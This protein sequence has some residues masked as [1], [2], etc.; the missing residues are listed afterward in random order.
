MKVFGNV[1]LKRGAEGVLAGGSGG[2]GDGSQVVMEEY[3][4]RHVVKECV[5]VTGA[6]DR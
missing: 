5:S 2:G 1:F 6:G 4:P 3:R